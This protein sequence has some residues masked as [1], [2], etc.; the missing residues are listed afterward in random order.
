MSARAPRDASL[1][2][3]CSREVICRVRIVREYPSVTKVRYWLGDRW[4][5]VQDTHPDTVIHDGGARAGW[6]P[7]GHEQSTS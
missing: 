6:T 4:S 1:V 2:G 3:L 7:V 5:D